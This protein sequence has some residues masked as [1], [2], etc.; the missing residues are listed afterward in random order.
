M[1]SKMVKEQSSL[2]FQTSSNY[3]KENI[4]VLQEEPKNDNRQHRNEYDYMDGVLGCVKV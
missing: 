4:K 2:S 1:E 3:V